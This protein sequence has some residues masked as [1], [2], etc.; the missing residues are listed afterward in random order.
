MTTYLVDVTSYNSQGRPFGIGR[1]AYYLA[2]SFDRIKSELAPDERLLAAYH[3]RGDGAV[4]DDLQIDRHAD[5]APMNYDPYNRGRWR[6]LRRTLKDADADLVHYVEGPQALPIAGQPT[7]VTCQD[8]IPI[9]DPDHYLKGRV[10]EFKWRLREYLTFHRA[11]RILAISETTAD[12]LVE[13]LRVPRERIAVVKLGVDHERFHPTAAPG[14]YDEVRREHGL[15]ARYVLYAGAT[16]V[17]KR[18]DLLVDTYQQVF[19][20]TGI[21]LAL[22]GAE[23]ARPKP[24]ARHAVAAASPGSVIVVGGVAAERLPGLYRQADLHVLPSIYEGFGL[25]VLEAMASGCPVI[26]TP[27]GALR[28]VGGDAVRYVTPDSARELEDAIVDLLQDAAARDCLRVRGLER[29]RL[30]TWERTARETLAMYRRATGRFVPGALRGVVE[31]G[32][33]EHRQQP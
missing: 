1:Y 33:R 5:P 29:A 6:W 18:V 25:T 30:F 19:R 15:P 14:E 4:T 16:D 8:L 12:S 11:R 21:P 31:H 9:L 2:R 23:F 10:H 7:I 17:R 3:L 13:C 22:V 32:P 24:A 27:G 28:E 26:T 20:A